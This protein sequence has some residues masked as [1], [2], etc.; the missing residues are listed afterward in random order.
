MIEQKFVRI[1]KKYS[2]RFQQI[3]NYKSGDYFVN[4]VV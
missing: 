4:K 2:I 3:R 1:K